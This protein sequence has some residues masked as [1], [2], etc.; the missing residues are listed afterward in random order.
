[1]ARAKDL[2]SYLAIACILPLGALAQQPPPPEP[3]S[4][5]I[6]VTTNFVLIPVGV[7]DWKGSVVEKLGA[8]D[9][10]L[11]DNGIRQTLVQCHLEAGSRDTVIILDQSESMRPELPSLYKAVRTFVNANPGDKISVITIRGSPNLDVAPTE[12]AEQL[13]RDLGPVIA[14]GRTALFDGVHLGLE[15]MLKARA[16]QSAVVILSDGGDNSSTHRPPELRDLAL[17]AGTVVHGIATTLAFPKSN[18]AEGQATM[19]L[20][21]EETGGWYLEAKNHDD[22]ITL[23]RRLHKDPHYVLGYVPSMGGR[24]HKIRVKVKRRGLRLTWRKSYTGD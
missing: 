15:H 20:L 9:F 21:A 24:S 22:L 18:E 6:S 14:G 10:E 5:R 4:P 13:F 12:D 1:M 7:R 17:E 3:A 23:V 2:A 8:A 16:P 19:K 11:F